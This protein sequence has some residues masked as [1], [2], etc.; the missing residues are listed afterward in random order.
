MPRRTRA[1]AGF[2]PSF[3][4]VDHGRPDAHELKH[5]VDAVGNELL[6]YRD[7]VSRRQRARDRASVLGSRVVSALP[8]RLSAGLARTVA[9]RQS[10]GRRP[11][12]DLHARPLTPAEA[13]G[14]G[15]AVVADHAVEEAARRNQVLTALR[16]AGV[17]ATVMP[18]G[19]GKPAAVVVRRVDR[20]RAAAAL[21]DGLDRTWRVVPLDTRTARPRGLTASRLARAVAA[22]DGFRVFRAA[23]GPAGAL[24]GAEVGVDVETW[25]QVPSTPTG[26]GELPSETEG[27]LVAPRR[28]A[29]TT[30]LTPAQWREAAVRGSVEVG[31]LPHLFDAA[32][33][34][35][36]VYTWVDG[37]DPVW[38]AGRLAALGVPAD[39]RHTA[40]ATHASRFRSQDELRYSLRSLETFAPWVRRVHIVTAGQVPDW[41][42]T[43]HPRVRVVDHRD[44]FTDPGVLPVFNSHAIESQLHHVPGLAEQYLYLND[45]VFFGRP[46]TP[47]LFFHSNGLAK[48]FT[49]SALMDARG[50]RADDSPVTSAAKNNRALVDEV[51]G[52]RVTHLFQHTPHPQLRSVLHQMEAAHPDQF[53]RVAA[54]TFRHPDDLSISSALHHYYAYALGRAVPGRLAYLYLDLAHP[55]AAA[56]LRRMLRRRELDVFCLNDSPAVGEDGRAELLGDFLARYYPVPSTFELPVSGGSPLEHPLTTAR[57][58]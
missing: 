58:A 6:L 14:C 11:G 29:W 23:P 43:G 55:R 51:F 13:R 21:A 38:N 39:Q 25:P 18:A 41:L 46:V 10:L 42:D 28:Q 50:H 40:E 4:V 37:E 5:T 16:D 44:I 49:S 31:P 7:T 15:T 57:V 35:D 8:R 9:R 17:R 53:A 48:F 20:A 27:T 1:L 56:R 52:R 24:L 36:V 33:P 47:S 3:V 54:S 12:A 30:Q 32:V 19:A 45:D 34:V 2:D 22:R 26:P